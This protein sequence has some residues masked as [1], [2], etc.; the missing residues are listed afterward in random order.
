MGRRGGKVVVAVFVFLLFVAIMG[1]IRS[2][3]QRLLLLNIMDIGNRRLLLRMKKGKVEPMEIGLF[4]WPSQA[5]SQRAAVYYAIVRNNG[6]PAK[7][8]AAA[9][10]PLI[11]LLG[12]VA[13]YCTTEFQVVGNKKVV[14]CQATAESLAEGRISRRSFITMKCY[15][16]VNNLEC[17]A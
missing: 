15:N 1:G 6:Q 7:P 16:Q 17:D 13:L 2:L 11:M 8:R 4:G 5:K 12:V 9:N 10:M 3:F 14:Q